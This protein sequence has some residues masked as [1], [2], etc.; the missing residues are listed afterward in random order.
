[1]ALYGSQ[2]SKKDTKKFGRP[3]CNPKILKGG[4]KFLALTPSV[5]R[6]FNKSKVLNISRMRLLSGPGHLAALGYWTSFQK[7]KVD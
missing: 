2:G 4:P 5:K 1:M 3:I 7:P 6:A